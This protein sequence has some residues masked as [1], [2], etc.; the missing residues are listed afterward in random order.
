LPR[1]ERL[2]SK[3]AERVSGYEVALKVEVVV[4]GSVDRQE[5]LSRSRRFETLHLAL[6]STNRQMRILGAIVPT[7]PL[8]MASRHFQFGLCCTIGT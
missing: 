4:D 6:A 3:D 5:A 2:L 1:P 7:S 8:F